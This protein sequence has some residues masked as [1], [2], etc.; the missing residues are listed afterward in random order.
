MERLTIDEI[1]A[2]C[3]RRVDHA[4]QFYGKGRFESV[5]MSHRIDK[6]Y[7]E[8][9][10]SAEYLE[11]LK[12]Y[13]KAEEQGLLLRLPCKVGSEVWYVEEYGFPEIVR[14]VVDGYLW[15]RSCGFALNVV[16]DKPIMEHFAYTRKEMPFLDIGKCVFLTR[17]EAETAL[18]EKGGAE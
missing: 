1:I 16:W 10:Q 14:G 3:K 7:W 11:E 12:E 8:H 15:Y 17:E 5:D 18:A 6:E 4:E 2:H 9:R 13:R